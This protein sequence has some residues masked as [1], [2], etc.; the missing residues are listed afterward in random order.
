MSAIIIS[1]LHSH[2]WPRF[3]TTTA[4]GTN[5][6]FQHLLDVLAQADEEIETRAV[7]DIIMLGDLTHRRY[8]VQFSVYA[9]VC[10]WFAKHIRRGRRVI[11]LVGNHDIESEGHHSLEPLVHMGV[12]VVDQPE[13]L[14]SGKNQ[15]NNWLFVPY[16]QHDI[17]KAVQDNQPRED[18][19]IAFMHYAFDGKILDSEYAVPTALKKS[20]MEAFDRVILGHIHSPSLE[21]NGRI[22][23]VGAPLHFDFGDQ[24]DRYCWLL[25]DNGGMTALPLHAPKFVTTT[26]P[27]LPTA[28]KMSGFLRVLGTPRNLFGD[29]KKAAAEG[30]WLDTLLVEQ[31]MPVEA[32][33]VLSHSSLVNEDMV[34]DYVRTQYGGISEETRQEIIEF[35][36]TCLREAAE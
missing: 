27:K 13:W 10:S 26:Y 34:R 1:D 18:G 2:A 5:S 12:M 15:P 8:Y 9:R 33:K 14:Q 30:G 17:V 29:V 25:D 32:I 21:E 7:E 24:G 3:A 20:D 4:D 11:A 28:P 6:R 31:T 35:G 36:L 16:L 22:V 19:S 23:Y